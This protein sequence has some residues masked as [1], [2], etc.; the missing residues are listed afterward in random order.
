MP[1]TTGPAIASSSRSL[2]PEL[3]LTASS[4]EAPM[5][6]PI[7]AIVP[8]SANTLTRIVAML[9]PA[10]RAASMLP[11]TAKMCRPYLVR[12]MTYWNPATKATRIRAASGSPRSWLKIPSATITAAATTTIRNTI[13][14]RAW[15]ASPAATRR[16]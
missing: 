13:G 11:P 16:R 9:M 2:P 8:A 3:W 5:M 10:R 1:A 4:L 6:P 12:A 15:S 14:R 7:A